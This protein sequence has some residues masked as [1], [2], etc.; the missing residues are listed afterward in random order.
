MKKLL[1]LLL[2]CLFLLP[3]HSFALSYS[4]IDLGA[5]FLPSDINT[6][7]QV[8]GSY[9]GNGWDAG[10]WSSGVYQSIGNGW[11]RGINNASQAVGNS[12][13]YATLW[14]NGTSNN[15]GTLGGTNSYANAI[16][17]AGQIAGSSITAPIG[18]FVYKHAT[19]WNNGTISDLGTLGGYLSEATDIN[20]S[21]KI[22][23]YS[24]INTLSVPT[25]HAFL[26]QDGKMI[27]LSHGLGNS[28]ATSINNNNQ[29]VGYAS[30]SNWS[31]SMATIWQNGTY[32]GLGTLGGD[33]FAF[34]INNLGEV[35]GYSDFNNGLPHAFLW[36]NGTIVDL[37]SFVSR[38]GWELYFAEAINDNG[39]I[40]GR[41][42]FDG[43]MHGYLLTVDPA[44]V[45]EPATALLLGAGLG[46]LALVKK[47]KVAPV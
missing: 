16:N 40:V 4:I 35:V 45:P 11:V 12:G 2:A 15:L 22:V 37:N 5:S 18:G 19:S 46:A 28:T 14:T 39:S 44:P 1:L 13:A 20:D 29:I 47:K 33:S 7:G 26:Y 25:T 43:E 24:M 41:G 8:A 9:S 23:G 27:D 32:D 42:M 6:S 36:R 10:I 3:S 34:D 17:N 38:S 21:G 31:K 30:Y